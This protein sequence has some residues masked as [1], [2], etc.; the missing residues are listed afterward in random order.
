MGHAFALGGLGPWAVIALML[1]SLVFGALFLMLSFLI[2]ERFT[3]PFGTALM[4]MFA[5]FAA[6]VLTDFVL[7]LALRAIP[8][9]GVPVV[10][11]ADF[12]I[13]FWIVKQMMRLPSGK[14]LS[15]VRAGVVTV[16]SFILEFLLLGVLW[17]FGHYGFGLR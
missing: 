6:L 16:G 1:L 15:Y 9:L 8:D 17:L 4:A 5:S 3:P 14:T 12:A 10:W 13:M 7:G 11:T 2:L